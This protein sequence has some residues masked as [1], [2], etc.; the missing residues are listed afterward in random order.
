MN[1]KIKWGKRDQKVLLFNLAFKEYQMSID[2]MKLIKYV[3]MLSIYSSF[4]GV[5]LFFFLQNSI[6]FISLFIIIFFL[7]AFCFYCTNFSVIIQFD[8]TMR[9]MMNAL[10]FVTYAN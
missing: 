2:I 9:Y 3:P 1:I 5:K 6:K 4:R 8:F 7:L 10:N